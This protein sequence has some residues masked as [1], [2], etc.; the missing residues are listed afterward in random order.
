[1]ILQAESGESLRLATVSSLS[2]SRS[3]TLTAR[4]PDS[5]ID[6]TLRLVEQSRTMTAQQR[7]R[8]LE[9][10]ALALVNIVSHTTYECI[11]IFTFPSVRAAISL[12]HSLCQMVFGNLLVLRAM[13]LRMCLAEEEGLDTS[14][15]KVSSQLGAARSSHARTSP[16][17]NL[18]ATTPPKTI[19]RSHRTTMSSSASVTG[20]AHYLP[21]RRCFLN[22]SKHH[23]LSSVP[24]HQPPATGHRPRVA[25]LYF[26]TTSSSIVMSAS[27]SADGN[28][29]PLYRQQR[30]PG[31]PPPPRSRAGSQGAQQTGQTDASFCPGL[32][33]Q[34]HSNLQGW[35][36]RRLR[37]RLGQPVRR[38]CAA[39]HIRPVE[40]LLL[41]SLGA[42][43]YLALRMTGCGSE[44]KGKVSEDSHG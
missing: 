31:E 40:G 8:M 19:L 21:L 22:T 26:N 38:E 16:Q 27:S 13:V 17:S 14:N 20:A 25:L 30:P 37:R 4:T 35:K 7:K 28:A 15:R 39:A 6:D 11:G 34:K 32:P 23:P 24:N 42:L 41:A 33:E 12:T 9:D 10:V 5:T 43:H 3:A 29:N 44:N 2:P 36:K 1:M 18:R